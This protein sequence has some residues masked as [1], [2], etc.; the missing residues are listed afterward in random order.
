M[1]WPAGSERAIV[2]MRTRLLLAV[3]SG[4]AGQAD[5]LGPRPE[6]A[7]VIDRHHAHR[8]G[9][10]I[11]GDDKP[12][13]RVD[14]QM[15]RVL[16]A[17]GLPVERGQTAARL[18]D[19]V[20]ADFVEIGVDRIEKSLGMVDGEERRINQ[21]HLLHLRP[22]AR[23]RVD[24]VDVDAVAMAFAFRRSEGA[25]IGEHRPGRS[26]LNR[27]RVRARLGAGGRSS[28]QR[29]PGCGERRSALQQH[30]AANAIARLGR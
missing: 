1:K 18:V 7:V 13:G 17:A 11:G 2:R 12:V 6:I 4:F 15:Y 22:V 9:A 20:G 26:R 3:G 21:R 27:R 5:E 16:A 10:V 19:R 8:P 28:E 14:R 24:P 29:R 30:A 23:N 25:D